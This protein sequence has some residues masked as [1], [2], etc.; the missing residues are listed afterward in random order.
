MDK[1]SAV[2]G[3]M[4]LVFSLHSAVAE[5]KDAL[6]VI[7]RRD[8]TTMDPIAYEDSSSQRACRSLYDTLIS[9]DPLDGRVLPGL[10]E[11]WEPLSDREYIFHLRKG[12]KFHNGDE[13]TAEDVRY[14]ILRTKAT[15]NARTAAYSQNVQDVQVVDD[16][17]VILRLKNVDYSFFS[18]LSQ[19]WSAI[20]SKKAVE[21]AGDAFA[22]NPVGTGPFKLV[23]W[24]K[25]CKYVLERF[26]EYWGPK[27][28]FRTLEVRSVP[29]PSSRMKKLSLGE[30]DIVFPLTRNDMKQVEKNWNLVL[31]RR[32]QTSILYLG[33]NCAKKPFDDVRVRRAISAALDVNG[34]QAAIWDDG[35]EVP[36][37]LIP[38]AIRYSIDD[39]LK[40][41][42]QDTALAKQLLAE[43]GVRN[44][45]LEIW[46]TERK[47]CIGMA[48][49]IQAQIREVG[50]AAEIR[51]LER[52]AY[53]KGLKAKAHDLYLL[54]WTPPVPD[55]NFAVA[56]LLETGASFNYAFFS[57][58]KLDELLSKGRSVPDGEERAAIYR[59][60]QLYVNEQSPMVYLRSGESLLGA[61]KYVKGIQASSGNAHSFREIYFE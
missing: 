7:D 9:L 6:I 44:L 47:E 31:Y 27:A 25:G 8:A 19:S 29:E 28:K 20:V 17:T 30:A 61:R 56:E 55:P 49:I 39:D 50:I 24:Q 54:C 57:D 37:S 3:M 43:A 52:G 34:I 14:S 35:G 40:P 18:S 11:S 16:Y 21:E 4:V 5:A 42:A 23:S 48:T 53:L 38:S 10:A 45:K 59:E 15:P 22:A 58:K 51:V 33:F 36:R 32:L 41:H 13:M 1:K 26:E 2:L 60:I 12:V 46:T